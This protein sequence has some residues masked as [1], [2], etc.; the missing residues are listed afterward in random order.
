MVLHSP[1]PKSAV[2]AR[3]D[4]AAVP[5]DSRHAPE[6]SRQLRPHQ[7]P[8]PEIAGPMDHRGG[9][10]A[11][12]GKR[13]PPLGSPKEFSPGSA[14]MAIPGDGSAGHAPRDFDLLFWRSIALR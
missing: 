1:R 3:F 4:Q 8:R 11:L 6:T 13:L 7:A 2:F 9:C 5:A 10:K 14:N 12:S